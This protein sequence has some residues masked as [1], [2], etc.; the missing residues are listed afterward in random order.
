MTAVEQ[1]VAACCRKL[2]NTA[3]TGAISCCNLKGASDSSQDHS[4]H[5]SA[6]L[7]PCSIACGPIFPLACGVVNHWRGTARAA[8]AR[9][10]YYVCIRSCC[11]SAQ[12]S[13]IWHL[14]AGCW[15]VIGGSMAHCRHPGQDLLRYRKYIWT[16]PTSEV[17]RHC[18]GCWSRALQLLRYA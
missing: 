18:Y 6:T 15:E 4:R 1:T 8:L 11:G 9:I 16:P 3:I 14:I 12:S 10:A 13:H 7:A 5:S 17:R 2:G